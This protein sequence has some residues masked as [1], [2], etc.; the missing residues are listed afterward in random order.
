MKQCLCL[1]TNINTCALARTT[2]RLT[3]ESPSR[4]RSTVNLL[5]AA[6][7]RYSVTEDMWRQVAVSAFLRYETYDPELVASAPAVVRR[8]A[9]SVVEE[10]DA[11]L[12]AVLWL[13][14]NGIAPQVRLR[15]PVLG[16]GAAALF[17]PRNEPM[18]AYACRTRLA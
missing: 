18:S 5:C 8:Q 2:V 1:D 7:C 4:F 10:E 12:E 16:C 9:L 15:L 3:G 14:Q 17:K 11:L 6:L 13:Y